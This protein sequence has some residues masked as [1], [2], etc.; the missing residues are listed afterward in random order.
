M[1]INQIIGQI[2]ADYQLQALS[3][4]VAGQNW[5][6]L[7]H[8]VILLLL[9][10][11]RRVIEV[12][13]L[14]YLKLYVARMLI[15]QNNDK[16]SIYYRNFVPPFNPWEEKYSKI[17][18]EDPIDHESINQLE[19]RVLQKVLSD[20]KK[21]KSAMCPAKLCLAVAASGSFRE[22]SRKTGVPT[23]TL[24]FKYRKYIKEVRKYAKRG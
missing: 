7:M 17:P 11:P 6:D 14:G 20:S 15:W 21:S 23:K 22:A 8:E 5:E 3:K 1:D 9:E 12:Y 13:N 18:D 24:I 2:H 19:I 10:K 16:Y 4:I